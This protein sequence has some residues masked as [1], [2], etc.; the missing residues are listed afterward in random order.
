MGEQR[1]R[2]E[3]DLREVAAR[4]QAIVDL[5]LDGIITIDE[6]G[7]IESFNPA[8]ERIFG[9]L[10]AEVIGRSVRML[11]PPPYRE[12]HDDYLRSYIATG[13]AK[14]IGIGREV[15][16]QRKDGSVFPLELGVSEIRL[17]GRRIF[18]GTAH[19]LTQRRRAE[20][21][22]Q[23]GVLASGLAHEIGTPMN[24][25]LGRAELVRGR[26]QDPDNLRHL[27]VIIEQVERIA[28]LIRQLLSLTRAHPIERRPTD[29]NRVVAQTLD[30]VQTHI[31]QRKITVDLRLDP[32]LPIAELDPDAMGQ[33]VLN[34]MV[35]AIDAIGEGAGTVIVTT[36]PGVATA[37]SAWVEE[38]EIAVADTGCGIPP[39]HLEQIF[40]PFFTTK[41]PG[42][43]TG[44]GLSVVQGIVRDHGGEILV[45]SVVRKGTTFRARLPV[46][47]E[48]A[49]SRESVVTGMRN[50]GP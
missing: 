40:A 10:A 15:V 32:K 36:G 9:Y 8:A 4:Y 2:I 24:V 27:D 46:R 33:L 47:A 25:I 13:K 34:L 17:G 14:I 6:S 39:E 41:D 38:V 12:Q 35:N 50:A 42:R 21:L 31:R 7:I 18:T 19:D 37:G 26:L 16:G 30:V 22:A 48:R 23:F 29:L 3:T 45:E 20:V 28:R 11:M 5:S 49:R 43:G 1:E 44:L